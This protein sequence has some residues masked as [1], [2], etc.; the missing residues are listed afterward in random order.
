MRKYFVFILAIVFLLSSG[1]KNS[2]AGPL[3]PA[4]DLGDN[5]KLNFGSKATSLHNNI[6]GLEKGDVATEGDAMFFALAPSAVRLDDNKPSLG[7]IYTAPLQGNVTSTLS[8]TDDPAN[9]K[10]V[11]VGFR[12]NIKLQ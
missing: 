8:L 11:A 5:Y 1:S 12:I 9:A 10:D 3:A 6:I 7:F 4:Y 2:Y